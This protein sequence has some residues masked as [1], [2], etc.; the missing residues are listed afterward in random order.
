MLPP[1]SLLAFSMAS[2]I[3][4][5]LWYKPNLAHTLSDSDSSVNDSIAASVWFFTEIGFPFVAVKVILPGS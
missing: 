4:S 5:I 1:V 2:V 3:F